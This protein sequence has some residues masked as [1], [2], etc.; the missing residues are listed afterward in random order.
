[1]DEPDSLA[2]PCFLGGRPLDGKLSDNSE[3][4]RSTMYFLPKLRFLRF[5]RG[6]SFA[7]PVFTSTYFVSFLPVHALFLVAL[8]SCPRPVRFILYPDI[9]YL[10]L[11]RLSPASPLAALSLMTFFFERPNMD[12]WETP[13]LIILAIGRPPQLGRT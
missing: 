11:T 3:S 5:C 12:G 8:K 2:D 6:D 9:S 1:M 7:P 10:L 4:P 13:S